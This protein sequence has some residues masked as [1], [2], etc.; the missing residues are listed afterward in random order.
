[1]GGELLT[2]AQVAELLGVT[3]AT[4][5]RWADSGLLPC[6]RTAGKHRRFERDAIEAFRRG[7]VGGPIEAPAM[8][9]EADAP[10]AAPRARRLVDR[11]L[12]GEGPLA[13]QAALLAERARV[14]AWWRVADAVG[15]ELQELGRRWADGEI[16]IFEEHRASDA[17]ARAL[18]RTAEVMPVR[19][20]APRVLLAAAEGEEHLLGLALANVVF[21]EAGWSP[22]WSGRATPTAEILRMVE[23]RAVDAVAL[24]ASVVA[25]PPVLAAQAETIGDACRAAGIPLVLGGRGAWPEPPPYGRVEHAFAGLAAWIAVVERAPRHHA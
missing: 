16:G 6:G 9:V 23:E 12:G 24:S 5:K 13:L 3:P 15:P 14:G 7:R 10:E 20:G 22:V 17:I 2:S 21:L 19:P 11:A 1:M 18:A 8:P 25:P 4:V